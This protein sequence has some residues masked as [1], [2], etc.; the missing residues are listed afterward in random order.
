MKLSPEQ[1]EDA[2]RMAEGHDLPNFSKA[3]TGKTHTALEAIRLT[4]SERN[5]VLCPKI[6]LDWW[7]TQATDYLGADVALFDS[8]KCSM[9]GDLIVSTYDLARNNSERFYEWADGGNLILDESQYVA[10]VTARRTQTVFGKDADLVGGIAEHFDQ[11]WPMTGTPKMNY[12]NDYWTQCAVLHPE[13]FDEVGATNY[14]KFC[15]M[16]TYKTQKQFH[17]NMQPKWMISG[18]TNQ[19]LLN[20]LLYQ[21]VGCIRRKEAP[22]IPKLRSRTLTVPVKLSAVTRRQ[23][24]EISEADMLKMLNDSDSIIAKAWKLV[25]LSKVA[26]VVPYV[27]DCVKESPILLGCWHRDVMQ[28]YED[29]LRKMGLIVRQVHGGTQKNHLPTIRNHFNGGHIDVLIGQMKAM[30]VSWNIQE[31]SN[32]VIVAE[33]HPTP[34]VRE[35]FYKRVYRRGQ[36]RECTVDDILSN[37]R[38]DEVLNDVR[39]RKVVS[40]ELINA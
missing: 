24:E 19:L 37:T 8:S 26:E 20:K 36:K 22:G 1:I 32:H 14:E 23:I 21:E 16:F 31:S 6:A 17:P 29:Q 11:V 4:K 34:A 35:Q 33:V 9:D 27:G 30:G 15:K 7:V 2:K 5:M 28:E 40:D 10:G 39:I 38:I 25:G 3:G 18:D 13:V 12:A